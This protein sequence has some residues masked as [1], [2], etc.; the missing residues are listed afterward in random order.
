ML[1]TGHKDPQTVQRYI[2]PDL[3]RT[4]PLIEKASELKR[5]QQKTSESEIQGTT[6]I[7][8]PEDVSYSISYMV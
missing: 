5:N 4:Q 8:K 7:A 3:E 1:Q 2:N 6:I